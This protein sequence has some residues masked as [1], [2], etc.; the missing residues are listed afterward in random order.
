LCRKAK[1]VLCND[2]FSTKFCLFYTYNK[3]Y[4]FFMKKLCEHIECRR[5][6]PKLLSEFFNIL[7]FFKID[8]KNREHCAKTPC[9]QGLLY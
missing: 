3:K 4:H 8:F 7:N 9:S 2:F 1:N 6:A 5:Y